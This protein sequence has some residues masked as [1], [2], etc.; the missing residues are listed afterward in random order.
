MKTDPQN[1]DY[2][3]ESGATQNFEPWCAEDE[4]SRNH[5]RRIHDDEDVDVDGELN[6]LSTDTLETPNSK[7]KCSSLVEKKE[8]FDISCTLRNLASLKVSRRK[9]SE[10]LPGNPTD[11]LTKAN[12]FDSSDNKAMKP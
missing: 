4:G 12:I 10:E 6:Q 11:S 5:V 3:V 8:G 1:S 7:L 9:F 2:V